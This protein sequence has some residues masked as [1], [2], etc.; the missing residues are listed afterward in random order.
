MLMLIRKAMQ[1]DWGLFNFNTSNVNVNPVV[2]NNIP[3]SVNYFNTSHVNGNLPG[4]IKKCFPG[5]HFNTSHVNVNRK[6]SFTVM[7]DPT[8]FQYISC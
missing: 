1:E 7:Y 2:I 3:F 4:H 6:C 5:F 8:V